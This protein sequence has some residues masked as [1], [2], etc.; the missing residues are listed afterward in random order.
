[1]TKTTE[2]IDQLM[3]L[4]HEVPQNIRARIDQCLKPLGVSQAAWRVLLRLL[5]LEEEGKNLVQIELAA[6]LGIEGP[7]LVSLLDRLE[8]E[9]LVERV[10]PPQDRRCKMIQLTDTGRSLA[11]EIM[12]IVMPMRE[13]LLKGVSAEDLANCIRVLQRIKENTRTI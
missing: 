6:L 4:I 1:M 5:K 3:Q 2:S 10:T 11:H 13:A 7:S 9:R 12:A 8:R